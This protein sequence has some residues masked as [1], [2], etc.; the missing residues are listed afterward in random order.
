MLTSDLS[1]PSPPT[2][3]PQEPLFCSQISF[4]PAG[5][6]PWGSLLA[7][8]DQAFYC[9]PPLTPQ[10]NVTS[11]LLAHSLLLTLSEPLLLALTLLAFFSLPTSTYN[12]I[13]GEKK[14]FLSCPTFHSRSQIVPGIRCRPTTIYWVSLL[15]MVDFGSMSVFSQLWSPVLSEPKAKF[16]SICT[17]LY[18][19]HF[20]LTPFL[21]F[22]SLFPSCTALLIL[23]ISYKGLN[24][25]LSFS[26]PLIQRGGVLINN[27][28]GL[29]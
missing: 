8:Q 13:P 22:L 26:Q 5:P 27:I 9:H 7:G 23:K 18:N 2:F 29:H 12:V 11:H 19:M 10:S 21:K 28:G 4:A 16:T 20:R 14:P 24:E 1:T 17:R 15:N 6:L 25:L 3:Q